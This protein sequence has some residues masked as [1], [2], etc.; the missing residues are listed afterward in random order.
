M[1]A[2]CMKTQ[3]PRGEW[4]RR[5]DLLRSCLTKSKTVRLFNNYY[6]LN[7]PKHFPAFQGTIA[8]SQSQGAQ[9]CKKCMKMSTSLFSAA[10]VCTHWSE[11][12]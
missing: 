4:G 5:S 9:K 10:T 3:N 11:M 12:Q 7:N 8:L 6:K 1:K 2:S